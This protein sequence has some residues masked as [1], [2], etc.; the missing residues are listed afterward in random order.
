MFHASIACMKEWKLLEFIYPNSRVK[1]AVLYRNYGA[2]ITSPAWFKSSASGCEGCAWGSR[3]VS[4]EVKNY[5]GDRQALIVHAVY[6]SRM[7]TSGCNTWVTQSMRDWS[8]R[9]KAIVNE[10]RWQSKFLSRWSIQSL[11]IQYRG[12]SL[13]SKA[14][15]NQMIVLWYYII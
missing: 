9:R 12:R 7:I 14:L 4:L 15:N 6:K 1:I 13:P 5:E 10:T 8:P 3:R 2:L 11:Y